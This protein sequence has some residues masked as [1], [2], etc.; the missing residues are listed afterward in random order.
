[1]YCSCCG[2]R[3][4]RGLKQHWNQ[5][6]GH[7]HCCPCV[8]KMIMPRETPEQVLSMCGVEGIN[9]PNAEQWEAWDRLNYPSKT[10]A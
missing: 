4:P 6:T 9:W 7:G 10:T 2:C 3:L 5:D 8:L 1:M